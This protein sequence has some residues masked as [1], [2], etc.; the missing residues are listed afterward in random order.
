MQMTTLQKDVS[1]RG[2]RMA[3]GAAPVDHEVII[4][5]AG[6]GGMGA[7]IQLNR[8][9]IEDILIV[10]RESDVG[11][12]WH[13]NTYPGLAV[14]IAST[15]YCYSFEPNPHWSRVYARGG[16]LKAYALHVAGKYNL[17]R[18][19]QFNS[20][21]EK[22]VY[23][24]RGRFWTVHVEG[25]RP[26]TARILILA[27]G[28]LSQPKL[29]DIP[30]LDSFEGKVIHTARW[31]HDYDLTGK[32]AAVIGTG[33]TAV[34]LLPEIAPKLAQMDV[35][36]RTPIWVTPKFD[37]RIPGNIQSLFERLPL[38]QRLARYFTSSVLETV[39]VT[40]ALH[41]KQFSFLTD[42]LERACKAHMA[43]QIPDPDL[44]RKLTPAYSFGCKRPTF[45]NDYYPT[46]MRPNVELITEGIDHI[47]PDGIVS[48]DGKK[49]KIDAL[50]LA[51]GY[52]VWE[53]GNFPA[54]DV[55]GREGTELGAWWDKN[56]YQSYE[57]IS[58]HGF[59]NLFYFAS[60]YAFTGLSY[61]FAIEAQMKHV[62]RCLAEMRRRGAT[63]FEVD[64]SAQ[65]RFVGQMKNNLGS[66]VFVNGS[67]ASSNSY[68]FNQHGESPLLRPT[69]TAM[70]LWSAG[71][72]PL[73]DYHFAA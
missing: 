69:P 59:P 12:T 55:I 33:A 49:R 3:A 11:G 17:R 16:E 71:H 65:A 14:D 6:F 39:M 30:G 41:Y 2:S 9:G 61:F 26:V 67:C 54:F 47:E 64:A 68:Y 57:G 19:M 36:Q 1:R 72:Y 62:S 32:R 42:S 27:T 48:R 43:R 21:V 20:T 29:P 70:G 56:G 4:V 5:G 60:P 37:A 25:R 24:S 35:Y 10:D 73:K 52:K 44:R 53:K 15:T 34:Q 46:F 22:A 7:A 51:T 63:E 58:V 8:M 45:S 23:D 40:G 18:Y 28:F 31:D 50:I 13:I 38:T 66:T